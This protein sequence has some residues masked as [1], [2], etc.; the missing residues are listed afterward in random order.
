MSMHERIPTIKKLSEL[1][2]IPEE[3]VQLLLKI[4]HEEG[5]GVPENRRRGGRVTSALLSAWSAD[6]SRDILEKIVSNDEVVKGI[7]GFARHHHEGT[8]LPRLKAVMKLSPEEQIE[9]ARSNIREVWKN[10]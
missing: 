5:I 4:F 2:G 8:S 3:H 9:I 7:L 1:S 6:Y 10:L